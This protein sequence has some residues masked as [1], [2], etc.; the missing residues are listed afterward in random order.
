MPVV[1]MVLG[2][3]LAIAVVSLLTRPPGP[4]TLQRYFP[5]APGT[6]TPT[7]SAATVRP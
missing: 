5:N 4:E 6:Y 1:F 3:A 7:A 2:S